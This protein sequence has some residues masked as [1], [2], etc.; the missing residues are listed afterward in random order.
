MSAYIDLRSIGSAGGIY[1]DPSIPLSERGTRLLSDVLAHLIDRLQG[2]VLEN[3]DSMDLTEAMRLL[4]GLD[5]AAVD[6][7]VAGDRGRGNP[8]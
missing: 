5:D 7:R 6:V 3:A 1:G 4:D 8:H 2:Y